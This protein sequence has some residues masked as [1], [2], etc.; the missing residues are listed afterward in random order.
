MRMLRVVLLACTLLFTGCNFSCS[1]ESG[2]SEEQVC[3]SEDVVALKVARNDIEN[4]LDLCKHACLAGNHTQ[5]AYDSCE[6]RD[7]IVHTREWNKLHFC[8]KRAKLLEKQE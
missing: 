8:I 4:K 3:P 5:K 1:V 2:D 7:C 6:R